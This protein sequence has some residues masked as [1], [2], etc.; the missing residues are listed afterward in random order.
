MLE[1]YLSLIEDHSYDDKLIEIYE[2]YKPWMLRTAYSFLHD[3]ELSQ[4]AVHDVFMNIVK[5]IRNIPDKTIDLTKSY[6]YIA[7]KHACIDIL[8]KRKKNFAFDIDS[9][10]SLHT[11]A[12]VEKEVVEKDLYEQM[13]KFIDEMPNIYKEVITLHVIHNIK[14]SKVA[15][16]LK[17]PF[18]TAQTRYLRA[19]NMIRKEFGDII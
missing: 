18:K 19:R 12:N 3:D 17:I 2:G 14:L 6:L 7:I 1:L 5:R 11:D 13:L 10:F 15:T 16:L 4:D 9:Q 8:N